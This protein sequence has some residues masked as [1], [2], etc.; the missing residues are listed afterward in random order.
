MLPQAGIC[1]ARRCRRSKR[2][3]AS[4]A[5]WQRSRLRDVKELLRGAR[6]RAWRG[7]RFAAVVAF[8][9]RS[10]SV[11]SFGSPVYMGSKV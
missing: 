6:A 2:A 1:A 3:I 11:C 7:V 4:A 8:Y 9:G 5:R 10:Y